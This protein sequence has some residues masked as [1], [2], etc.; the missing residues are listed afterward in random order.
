MGRI[1]EDAISSVGVVGNKNPNDDSEVGDD[2]WR[3]ML[4]ALD[5]E[6]SVRARVNRS[7]LSEAAVAESVSVEAKDAAPPTDPLPGWL[8]NRRFVGGTTSSL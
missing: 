1:G 7:S 8:N 6:V 5:A 3:V 2:D 4:E